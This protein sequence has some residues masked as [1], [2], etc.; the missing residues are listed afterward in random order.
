VTRS[1]QDLSTETVGALAALED[2][3]ES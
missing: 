3:S 2:S 1:A